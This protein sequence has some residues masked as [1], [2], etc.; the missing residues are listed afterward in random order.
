MIAN[1]YPVDIKLTAFVMDV[2]ADTVKASDGV[3]IE[4]LNENGYTDVD[5][6]YHKGDKTKGYTTDGWYRGKNLI[7]D[8]NDVTFKPGQALWFGGKAGYTVTIPAP[9]FN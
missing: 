5:Y 9:K 8:T 6:I 1:P 7:K 2:G 4:I 3:K